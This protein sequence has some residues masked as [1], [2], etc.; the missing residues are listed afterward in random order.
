MEKLQSELREWF[1]DPESME[2]NKGFKSMKVEEQYELIKD[3]FTDWSHTL[4]G[5]KW[6]TELEI[7]EDQKKRL[8]KCNCEYVKLADTARYARPRVLF[9]LQLL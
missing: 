9:L 4:I 6:T 5:G 7:Q 1:D 8:G 2:K 3:T